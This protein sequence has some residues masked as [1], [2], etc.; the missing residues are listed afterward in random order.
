MILQKN[1]KFIQVNI[2]KVMYIWRMIWRYDWSSQLY[3]RLKQLWNESLKNSGLNG[4]RT[5]DIWDTS[6]VLYQLSCQANWEQAMCWAHIIPVKKW[7]MW[8][9]QVK[10]YEKSYIW[11]AE[12]DM[13]I[14]FLS[15]KQKKLTA[16]IN[17]RNCLL[18]TSW[19]TNLP[20]F[21]E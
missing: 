13:K 6:A 7:K 10:I 20:Q 8:K 14:W 11:T 15:C 19:L 18:D 2:W 12:N 1:V 9:I 4:I 5:Y 16:M 17:L 3:A 21:Q